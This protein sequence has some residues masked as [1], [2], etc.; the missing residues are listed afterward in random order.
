MLITSSLPSFREAWSI[1]SAI[2]PKKSHTPI[3]S[4]IKI[5]STQSA[6]ILGA[7]DIDYSAVVMVADCGS[8]SVGTLIIPPSLSAILAA[9]TG[10]TITIESTPSGATVKIGRASWTLAT[11]SP[12]LYP[13]F[14]GMD[15][16]TAFEADSD[17]FREALYR[18]LPAA[19]SENSGIPGVSLSSG[20]LAGFDGSRIIT[21]SFAVTHP[22]PFAPVIIPTSAATKLSACLRLGGQAHFGIGPSSARFSV[23]PAIFSCGLLNREFVNMESIARPSSPTPF[24]V[25]SGDLLSAIRQ[26]TAADTQTSVI[27]EFSPGLILICGK[28]SR[29]ELPVDYAGG[30]MSVSFLSS[31]LQDSLS[32]LGDAKIIG[33]VPNGNSPS[34]IQSA[35]YEMILV[36]V[37]S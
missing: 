14:Y 37:T 8:D 1:V 30:P 10:D 18:V 19:I 36:P 24:S 5:R 22:K 3:R 17:D 7:G 35:N 33:H 29:V 16:P 20:K 15:S 26:A 25:D 31:F 6:V 2:A 11:E 21:A 4:N 34:M 9:A 27:L 12:D 23:G 32:K 13:K 28:R